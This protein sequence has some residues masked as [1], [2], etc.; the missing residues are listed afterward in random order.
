MIIC[1]HQLGA[2]SGSPWLQQGRQV[3][4]RHGRPEF[5]SRSSPQKNWKS[6]RTLS[7]WSDSP[8]KGIFCFILSVMFLHVLI[9]SLFQLLI[10]TWIAFLYTLTKSLGY[11]LVI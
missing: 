11:V 8:V 2:G 10:S 9:D 3:K 7:A 4:G 5:L 6:P 1:R